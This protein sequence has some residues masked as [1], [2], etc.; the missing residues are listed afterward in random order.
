MGLVDHLKKFVVVRVCVMA[1]V[2]LCQNIV[3]IPGVGC[4]SGV[5]LTWFFMG[6]LVLDLVLEHLL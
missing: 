6:V 5:G 3:V 1:S 4:C 2:V